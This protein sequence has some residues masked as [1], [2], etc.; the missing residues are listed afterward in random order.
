MQGMWKRTQKFIRIIA[1][2]VLRLCAVA[3]IKKQKLNY[4][5]KFI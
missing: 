1:T 4:A 3:E 2:N 5:D